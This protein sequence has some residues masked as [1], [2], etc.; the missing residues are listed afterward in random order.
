MRKC[1]LCAQ[2]IEG[3]LG[4]HVSAHHL[5]ELRGAQGDTTQ[6]IIAGVL[7]LTPLALI[8]TLG[9]IVV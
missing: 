6:K 2:H 4:Q 7:V 9:V 8:V 1:N 5:K 3:D